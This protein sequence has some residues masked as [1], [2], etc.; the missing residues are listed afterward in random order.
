VKVVEWGPYIEVAKVFNLLF[1]STLLEYAQSYF[2]EHVGTTHVT[3][4]QRQ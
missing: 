2:F 4:N 1:Q 3:I